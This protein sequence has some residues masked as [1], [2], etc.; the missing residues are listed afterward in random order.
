MTNVSKESV[1]WS[2]CRTE[3]FIGSGK[4]AVLM[5]AFDGGFYSGNRKYAY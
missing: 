2:Q 3:G 4:G 5:L 1:A